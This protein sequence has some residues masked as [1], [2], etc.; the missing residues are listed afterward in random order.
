MRSTLRWAPAIAA[1][2]FGLFPTIGRFA[3]AED[4]P[5]T[6]SNPTG[7]WLPLAQIAGAAKPPA[8][9]NAPNPY[10]GN[11]A[12]IQEGQRL[13]VEM[14]CAGCHGYDA[15]GAMGPNLTDKLWRHGGAPASVYASISQGRSMGMPAWGQALPPESIW[16]LVTYIESL[17]GMYPP[18]GFT[19]SFEG[20]RDGMITPPGTTEMEKILSGLPGT[21]PKPGG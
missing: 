7:E 15:K 8:N 19:A 11:A 12:A 18:S 6:Q 14:N 20:D 1:L 2:V 21:P 3:A 4:V 9:A 5:P 16:K 17:G 13:F 10:S